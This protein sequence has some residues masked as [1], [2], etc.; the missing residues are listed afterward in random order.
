MHS[1]RLLILLVTTCLF[2]K[3]GYAQ[4]NDSLQHYISYAA[5]GI[6]NKTNTSKSYLLSNVLRFNMK[7]K[8]I[9]LNSTNSFIYGEQQNKITNRD[10]SSTFDCNVYSQLPRFYY[11]GLVNYDKSYSLKI[12]N[13]LQTGLGI[14]YSIIDKPTVFL[15]ISDGILYE[16]SSLK[17]TDST[18]DVYQTFRNSLR[19]RYKFVIKE[20][21]TLNGSN[22]F[23]NSLSDANDYIIQSTNSLSVKLRKWLS[24]TT[25]A[26]YNKVQRTH[27]ENLLV[28]FGLT[29]EKYF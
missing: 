21:I 6:L 1:S 27:R 18:N 12:N 26:T 13:R 7:K 15:N 23:Q 2:S 10:L 19:F 24:F 4:L 14:A 28:T 22:F 9:S 20:I 25:A 3:Q 16:S 5:T 29:A 11:W 17:K 8:K